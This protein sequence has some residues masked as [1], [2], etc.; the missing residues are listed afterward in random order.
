M[1]EIKFNLTFLIYVYFVGYQDA[2]ISSNKGPKKFEDVENE[3]DEDEEIDLLEEEL[4]FEQKFAAKYFRFFTHLEED[5][6][7][8]FVEC[9]LDRVIKAIPSTVHL[10][11]ELTLTLPLPKDQLFH[12]AGFK[13]A[14][15]INLEEVTSTFVIPTP[16]KLSSKLEDREVI[17]YPKEETPVWLVFK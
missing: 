12:K 3:K 16:A 4:T 9:G 7:A 10:S 11:V 17:K 5:T 2:I 15:K 8:I 13:H 14:T 1:Y 6:F